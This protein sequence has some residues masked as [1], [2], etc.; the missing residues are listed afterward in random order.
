MKSR[1]IKLKNRRVIL[2]KTD[3]GFYMQ[4]KRL[5]GREVIKTDLALSDEAMDALF[6]LYSEHNS[7][8]KT[9]IYSLV[10]DAMG[11][12]IHED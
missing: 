1:V 5:E 9:L 12:V 2:A 6:Q 11:D 3:G 4:F 10:F 7:M 8:A